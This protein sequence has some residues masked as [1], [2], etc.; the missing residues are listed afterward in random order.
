MRVRAFAIAAGL[1]WP[2]CAFSQTP[3]FF[4][5]GNDLFERCASHSGTYDFG[6]C[7]GYVQGLSDALN[8]DGNVCA[9]PHITVGQARDIIML[10]LRNK[11]E[12][13]HISASLLAGTA[14]REAFPARNRLTEFSALV[15]ATKA[16]F[17]K[18]QISTAT[19][20]RYGRKAFDMIACTASRPIALIKPVR[21]ASPCKMSA[22][23]VRS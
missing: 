13:R 16:F 22:A 5:T 23:S 14:L 17:R 21:S 15:M 3:L 10:Y 7:L 8:M 4:V 9:P 1:L 12:Y 20:W 11:P 18:C 2:A 6:M 19:C